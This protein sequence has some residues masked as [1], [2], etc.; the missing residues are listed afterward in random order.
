[1]QVRILPTPLEA[2]LGSLADPV[3][4]ISPCAFALRRFESYPCYMAK[5]VKI[6]MTIGTEDDPWTEDEID[7]VISGDLKPARRIE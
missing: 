2:G 6:E 3:G 7:A 4:L 5:T 1:M